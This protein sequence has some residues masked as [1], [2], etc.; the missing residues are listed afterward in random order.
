MNIVELTVVDTEGK[1][2]TWK[3]QEGFLKIYGT[4]VDAHLI[5][6]PV[7]TKDVKPTGI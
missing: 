2:H 5:M 1:E 4:S 7:L 3:G 6:D